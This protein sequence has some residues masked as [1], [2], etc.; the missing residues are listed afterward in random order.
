MT[1][2]ALTLWFLGA[3]MMW[4]EVR[5]HPSG[6]D[7]R[8]WFYSDEIKVFYDTHPRLHALQYVLVNVGAAVLWPIVMALGIAHQIS[9][10]LK[11]R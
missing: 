8:G 4:E 5:D 11:S 1:L 9:Q 6:P 10:I 7:P 3:Y 2:V